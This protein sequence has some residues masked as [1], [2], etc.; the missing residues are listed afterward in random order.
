MASPS[1]QIGS[2]DAAKRASAPI[3]DQ[4]DRERFDYLP[5]TTSDRPASAR[6][7]ARGF[8]S[9]RVRARPAGL[10]MVMIFYFVGGCGMP[11]AMFVGKRMSRELKWARRILMGE[12]VGGCSFFAFPE[13]AAGARARVRGCA[14]IAVPDG[15]RR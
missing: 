9:S 11:R 15:E 6:F 12:A 1:A 3:P 7:R 5:L 8:R 2:S 4:T 14:V 10:G 13:S